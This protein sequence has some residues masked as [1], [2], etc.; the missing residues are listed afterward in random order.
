MW[1]LRSPRWRRRLWPVPLVVVAV[2]L[3]YLGV[4]LSSPGNPGNATGPNVNVPGYAQPKNVPFTR[5]KQREVRRVLRQFEATAVDRRD[6]ASSWAISAPAL[7]E[8]VSRKD[9]NEGNL[10]VVPYPA[11]DKGLGTWSFVQYS[12]PR[13]VGLEVFLF[14]KPGSGYSAMTA[15]T[16]LVKGSDGQW[17]VSYWMPKSF[18]GPPS[19]AAKAKVKAKVKPA[20][21]T[22]PAK[23]AGK[24]SAHTTRKAAPATEPT[25]TPKV[26]RIWWILPIAVVSLILL[27]PLGLG[28]GTWYRNR[29]A[30]RE[31]ARREA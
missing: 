31:Y 22:L 20:K 15:D 28:V 30:A 13:T 14:P 4:H 27:V 17:R 12:Y 26:N 2:P 18:H 21:H 6:V 11:A 9:W 3:I 24:R 8:G 10:P 19:V 29:R 7:R 16:E 23:A 5:A 25:G 1:I